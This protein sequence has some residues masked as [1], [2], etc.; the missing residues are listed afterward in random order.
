MLKRLLLIALFVIGSSICYAQSNDQSTEQGQQGQQ[1]Q[2][3]TTTGQSTTNDQSSG[4]T[5]QNN[6][7]GT[8]D[9]STQNR[10]VTGK[11]SKIDHD[12]MTITVK[13]ETTKEAQQFTLSSTATMT[14][15]GSSIT[16]SQ[17]KK[18]DH[19]SLEVDGTNTVLKV[20]VISKTSGSSGKQGESKH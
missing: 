7:A 18:G 1:D 16:S 20:D 8:T 4:A 15:D 19:V 2:P 6:T 11:I 14:K 12:K 13:D 17:L 10:M 3:G 9:Q 5:D